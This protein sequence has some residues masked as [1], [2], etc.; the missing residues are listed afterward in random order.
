VKRA[1][2]ALYTASRNEVMQSCKQHGADQHTY[3]LCTSKQ[4]LFSACPALWDTPEVKA[5][6]ALHDLRRGVFYQAPPQPVQQPTAP[7][8]A[9]LSQLL[10]HQPQQQQQQ[11][12]AAP[13]QQQQQSWG[14]GSMSSV[15]NSSSSTSNNGAAASDNSAAAS[16][17]VQWK[18]PYTMAT[19][20]AAAVTAQLQ[21]RSNGSSSAAQA[22]AQAQAQAPQSAVMEAH[23]MLVQRMCEMGFPEHQVRSALE[24]SSTAV[25]VVCVSR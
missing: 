11:Q 14:F 15:N 25:T 18:N 6:F 17:G 5:F 8:L 24:V 12:Q 10:P 1:F 22:Q 9:T 19:Q 20:A 3:R 16:N 4:L 2:V 7:M 13:Q 21:G 23:P